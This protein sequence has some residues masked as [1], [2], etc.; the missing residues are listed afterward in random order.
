MKEII[1]SNLEKKMIENQL[2]KHTREL[3]ISWI[4]ELISGDEELDSNVERRIEII[5]DSINHLGV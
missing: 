1:L 4:D 3:T 2:E 5:L